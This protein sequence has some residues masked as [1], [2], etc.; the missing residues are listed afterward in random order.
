[1]HDF[2]LLQYLFARKKSSAFLRRKNSQSIFQTL[3][4]Q[5][6]R[7]I[8]NAQYRNSNYTIELKKKNSHMR[9]FSLNITNT[10]KSLCRIMLKKKQT[11]PQNTLFRDDLFDEICESMK[12]KNEAMIIRN[13]FSFICFFSQVLRIYD[14]KHLNHLYESVNEN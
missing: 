1:M 6:S 9:K 10:S 14:A 7:K 2:H 4:D 8:K 3:S 5:L 12:R 13:I 11:F